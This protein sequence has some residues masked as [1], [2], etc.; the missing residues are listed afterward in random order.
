[1]NT[2]YEIK[3]K[4]AISKRKDYKKLIDK[5]KKN[6]PSDLDY[7]TNTLHDEAFKHIDCLQCG[8]CCRTTGPLL[9]NKDI[10]RLAKHFRLKPAE[11]TDQFLR[12][13]EDGDFV[14]KK[15]PCPFLGSDNYC[16]VYENRPNAC[17]EYPHTQQS[18]II[19][20]LGIT[21]QNAMICPAVAEV[22]A[23]LQKI[24]G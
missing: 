2:D 13:D 5:L 11:F 10:D 14:F 7:I 17:R 12:I 21:Y 9:L 24:Y 19:Q 1:M 3:L 16:A 23:G 4:T 6:K 20:K 15:M 8:N 18:R 22:V